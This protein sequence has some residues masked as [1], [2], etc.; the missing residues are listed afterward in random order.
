MNILPSYILQRKASA[1][2]LVQKYKDKLWVSISQKWKDDKFEVTLN[3]TLEEAE[4]VIKFLLKR[5]KACC[6]DF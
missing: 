2:N 4:E 5:R 6:E 3:V 1:N